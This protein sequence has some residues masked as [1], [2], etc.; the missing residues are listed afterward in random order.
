MIFC[1]TQKVSSKLRVACT[2]VANSHPSMV[3]W[4]C[5]LITVQRR[6][7]FLFTHASSLFSFWAPAAGTTR[8]GFGQM[9]RRHA[10]DTLRDYGFSDADAAKVI[11]DGPDAFARATDRGVIGSM[12][13][14]GKMLRQAVDYEGSLERLGPRA[15]ND[16]TNDSPMRRIGMESPA[17][18]LRQVLRAERPHDITVHRTGPRVARSGQ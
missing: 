7:F 11:D 6:Q 4:Y 8:D 18:Y 17:E 1:A 3:E 15:M 12:V 9:F 10:T 2:A 13:D 14:Y 16:I 5:N